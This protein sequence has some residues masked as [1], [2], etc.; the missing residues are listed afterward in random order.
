MQS[1]NLFIAS[2][3]AAKNVAQELWPLLVNAA[4]TKNLELH[5]ERWWETV[6]TPGVSTLQ[7]LIK[8]CNNVHFALVLLTKDDFGE[9]KGEHVFIPRDN[10]IYEAGLFTGSFGPD[11]E[12]CFLLTSCDDT[13]LPTDLLGLTKIKIPNVPAGPLSSAHVQEISMVANDVVNAIVKAKVMPRGIVPLRG[14]TELIG[15]EKLETNGGRLKKNSQVMISAEQPVELND[16]DFAQRVQQNMKGRIRYLYF[17]H[18]DTSAANVIAELI[19]SLA[20]VGTQ[21]AM[22]G[23][24]AVSEDDEKKIIVNLKTVSEYLCIY[25]LAY[26]PQLQMCIHNAERYNDA[27]CYL[28]YSKEK[29]P[30]FIEWSEGREA[31][32]YADSLRR[33]CK[34]P[35]KIGKSASIFRATTEFDFTEDASYKPALWAE[36]Q[37]LFPESLWDE[38]AKYC[39]GAPTIDQPD[40]K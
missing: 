22:G 14:G 5:V 2:S 27:A 21:S 8:Q 31:K 23:D 3:G 25:L 11:P 10:C 26:R 38:V 1:Y 32:R 35:V 16:P 24:S 28:R 37:R 7:S 18:A 13:A 30:Q 6:F 17:F 4:K 29:D 40:G 15:W 33:S 36:L 34:D 39:F 9:K 12:R 19:W 20:T